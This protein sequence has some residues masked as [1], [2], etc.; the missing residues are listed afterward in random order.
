ML[1]LLQQQLQALLSVSD[2]SCNT[3]SM[4][5]GGTWRWPERSLQPAKS[6]VTLPLTSPKSTLPVELALLWLQ[7]AITG[8]VFRFGVKLGIDSTLKMYRQPLSSCQYSGPDSGQLFC[9]FGVTSFSQNDNEVSAT[10]KFAEAIWLVRPHDSQ[11]KETCPLWDIESCHI[12][13]TR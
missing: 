10:A 11:N 5:D 13:V 2:Q 4:T 1:K 6:V 9:S 12:T 3:L 7:Q 8:S